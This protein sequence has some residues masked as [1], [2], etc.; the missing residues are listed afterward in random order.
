MLDP[1]SYIWYAICW[2]VIIGRLA[3][4]RLVR[5]GWLKLELE[6]GLVLLAMVTDTILLAFMH[7]VL[8]T[9]SNLIPPGVDPATF[10]PE[11]IKERIYGSKLVLVVEQMQILT[12][13]ILKACM[14]LMYFRLT[15]LLPQQ[16]FVKILAV[17]VAVAFVVMEIL[18]FGVWCRPMNQYWAVPTDNVQCS[19]AIH[20]L[21]TNMVFNI[22]SD[23]LLMIIPM[24]LLRQ[25]KLP[26]RN[27]I[28]LGAVFSLGTFVIVSAIVNKYFSFRHPFAP[29]WTIWYLRES[30]TAILCANLPMTWPILRRLFGFSAWQPSSNG[31]NAYG[32]ASR[33]HHN[34]SHLNGNSNGTGRGR[35]EEG[36]TD[37]AGLGRSDSEERIVATTTFEVH[38]VN[39]KQMDLELSAIS[40]SDNSEHSAPEKNVGVT[41]TCKAY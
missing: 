22:S 17:Y 26:L 16:A 34:F 29:N 40:I 27:K 30:F 19:A 11:D 15:T 31:P 2:V 39:L 5:G 41:T 37:G 4:R 1:E 32:G 25:V 13:W 14:L 28:A 8:H 33:S 18:Y 10:S 24:P 3:S 21:I 38:T 9:N 36:N 6:D 20:H 23:I 35:R 7:I 12:I